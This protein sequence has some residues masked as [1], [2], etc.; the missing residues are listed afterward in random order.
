[1][2]NSGQNGG[3][4]GLPSISALS[5]TAALLLSTKQ[6]P[7]SSSVV[8]AAAL[9]A[10]F[11]RTTTGEGGEGHTEES[12]S[13]KMSSNGGSGDLS[14]S[15]RQGYGLRVYALSTDAL[16]LVKK[17][18]A[19]LADEL[20]DSLIF[21]KD[22]LLVDTPP[23]D[24]AVY[25]TEK[26]MVRQ[27][28]E[29]A[30][31]LESS[32]LHRPPQLAPLTVGIANPLPQLPHQRYGMYRLNPPEGSRLPIGWLTPGLKGGGE[33]NQSPHNGYAFRDMLGGLKNEEAIDDVLD[34]EEATQRAAIAL[35]LV[36][37]SPVGGEGGFGFKKKV[38]M[39]KR[40]YQP[41]S[42]RKD[43]S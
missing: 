21:E 35:A 3:Y 15:V 18:D 7:D 29:A 13:R 5:E 27:Q 37:H 22:V 28:L 9:L 1:M 38:Q 2:E 41:T 42:R 39:K 24:K 8:N 26:T 32:L 40:K 14:A 33:I 43:A 4:P 12:V 11:I 19:A 34:E 20:S 25:M 6:R 23:I 30:K 36:K 31:E 16:E 10:P 17:K